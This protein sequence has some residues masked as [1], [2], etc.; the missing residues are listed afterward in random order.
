MI[1]SGHPGIQNFAQVCGWYHAEEDAGKIQRKAETASPVS[2]G[3][4]VPGGG[5]TEKDDCQDKMME[6][7]HPKR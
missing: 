6:P 5:Q 4:K 7:Q 3:K 2:D 1:S